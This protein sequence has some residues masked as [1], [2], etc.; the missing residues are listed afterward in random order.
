MD[1]SSH[2]LVDPWGNVYRF[3]FDLNGDGRVTRQVA[4]KATNVYDSVIAWSAGPDGADD[5]TTGASG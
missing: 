3:L 2:S 5:T 4:G 1:P